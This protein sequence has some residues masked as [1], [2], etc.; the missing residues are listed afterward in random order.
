MSVEDRLRA[1]TEAVTASMRPVRPLDLPAD[2]APVQPRP[3]SRPRWGNRPG[4]GNRPR[5]GSRRDWSGWLIPLAAAAAVIIVAATLVTMKAV[6]GAA[7]QGNGPSRVSTPA[8]ANQVP[9]YYV[10][11]GRTA[12]A[13]PFTATVGL[14]ATGKSLL[15]VKPPNGTSFGGVTAAVDDRTFVLSLMRNPVTDVQMTTIGWDLLR[16]TP[17]TASYTLRKLSIPAPS[18]GTAATGFALSPDGTKLA[19]LL[20]TAATATHEGTLTL[21]VYSVATGQLLRSWQR[22]SATIFS[23]AV[24]GWLHPNNSVTWLADGHH[25]AFSYHL[26]EGTTVVTGQGY[27]LSSAKEFGVRRLDLEKPG[28]DLIG[29][30]TPVATIDGWVNGDCSSPYPTADGKGV[31]CGTDSF[32]KVPQ[33]S[34]NCKAVSPL[35]GFY[36][37]SGAVRRRLLYTIPPAKPDKGA[38]ETGAAEVLWSDPSASTLVGVVATSVLP[39]DHGG[40][41]EEWAIGV[42]AHGRWTPLPI[43]ISAANTPE[44]AF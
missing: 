1:T 15:A 23:E 16:V 26:V 13:D 40:G 4:R 42:L 31:V 27:P 3:G 20:Q 29:A 41:S 18:P 33:G 39:G 37:Y 5:V 43:R 2:A 12:T 44:I 35:A 36:E 9:A 25:L 6:S 22:T 30:S 7:G 11:I 17:G 21:R 28:T 34:T 10:A 14:T 32:L 19:V 38:C 24:G 8:A